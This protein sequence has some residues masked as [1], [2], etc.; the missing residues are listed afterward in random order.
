MSDGGVSESDMFAS[1]YSLA[2]LEEGKDHLSM[3]SN[4]QLNS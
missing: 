1:E 2:Q 3:K 4:P